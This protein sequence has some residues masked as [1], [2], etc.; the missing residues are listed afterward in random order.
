MLSPHLRSK[1]T[2]VCDHGDTGFPGGRSNCGGNH[3]G[4]GAKCWVFRAEHS[5]AEDDDERTLGTGVD[6]NMRHVA[7]SLPPPLEL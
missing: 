5:T 6:E 2:L 7:E 1:H 4:V 3:R